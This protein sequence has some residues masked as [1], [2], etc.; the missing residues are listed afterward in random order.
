M[1]RARTA[2]GVKIKTLVTPQSLRLPFLARNIAGATR[3]RPPERLDHLG[4]AETNSASRVGSHLGRLPS[5]DGVFSHGEFPLF[6]HG[7]FPLFLSLERRVLARRYSPVTARDDQTITLPPRRSRPRGDVIPSD[8]ESAASATGAIPPS[9]RVERRR[10]SLVAAPRPAARSSSEV[11]VEDVLP[12]PGCSGMRRRISARTLRDQIRLAWAASHVCTIYTASRVFGRTTGCTAYAGHP[13]PLS[14]CRGPTAARRP[15]RSPRL[16]CPPRTF[17][18]LPSPPFP[19]SL[20]RS[21]A[22]R[23]DVTRARDRP[24]PSDRRQLL[25]SLMELL[26]TARINRHVPSVIYYLFTRA[27]AARTRALALRLSPSPSLASADLRFRARTAVLLSSSSVLPRNGDAHSRS[28][29]PCI[30]PVE[31]NYVCRDNASRVPLAQPPAPRPLPRGICVASPLHPRKCGLFW[32][33]PPPPHPRSC[34]QSSSSALPS[35]P[36]PAAA[37][38]GFHPVS[39]RSAF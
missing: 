38:G 20:S 35:L 29:R 2:V 13:S 16:R 23:P 33:S 8:R 25:L 34:H 10:I 24:G 18:H 14:P 28:F 27:F 9:R 4:R 3:Y 11:A 26:M 15:I 30:T 7:E 36:L 6:S 17:A 37:S 22:S 5:A 31:N 39:S 1:T 32:V 12:F 21:L 19:S